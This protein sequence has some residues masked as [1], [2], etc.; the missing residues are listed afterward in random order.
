VTLSYRTYGLN[1]S[2]NI[3]IPGLGKSTAALPQVDVHV[4]VGD[5]PAWACDALQLPS[6]VLH[7]FPASEETRDPSFVLTSYGE[8]QFFQLYY[9]DGFRFVLNAAATDIWAAV[10]HSQT[11]E[12]LSTYFLGPV[13]GYVLRRRGTTA[14]HAS[15]FSLDGKAIVL[16]GAAGAGKSTSAAALALRGSSV[17]CED[18]AAVEEA[19]HGFSV[20]A[21]YPRVCLWPQSVAI[22]TGNANSLPLITPSWDKRF[23][24]L[25]GI[26]ATHDAQAR[27]LGAIYLLAPRETH[28]A[29]RV[30]EVPCRDVLLELVQNTYMNWVL[31]RRQRAAEFE[32][33]SRLVSRVPVRRIV[34]HRDSARIDALCDLILS[35]AARLLAN[36]IGAAASA[37]R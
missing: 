33:L 24:P 25:D 19:H 31:D 3:P 22:L 23:L 7:S 15:A 21:G 2:S 6:T 32:L 35:D 4:C 37:G 8:G 17:L 16:V 18:I 27:P 1:L 11:I 30:E 10:D 34:P 5:Q 9:S 36:R 12:D 20:Q 14:L 13:M 29:P 26:K 28:N